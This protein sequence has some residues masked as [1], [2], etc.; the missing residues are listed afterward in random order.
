MKPNKTD[1]KINPLYPLAWCAF[2]LV[3]LFA[4][5]IGWKRHSMLAMAVA[6]LAIAGFVT[7][8]VIAV[9]H[10]RALARQSGETQH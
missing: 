1:K 3:P 8:I 7:L 5:Y 4:F 9:R 2:L 10:N 6:A